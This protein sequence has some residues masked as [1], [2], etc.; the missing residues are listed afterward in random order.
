MDLEPESLSAADRYGLLIALIAPRPIAWVSTVDA[1]GRPNLAPFSFFTGV[2][3]NPMTVCFCPANHRSGGKKDTLANVEATGE[4]VVNVVGESLAERMNQTSA[5]Y[6][7]GVSEF[8]EAGLTPAPSARV[9]PPYVK[10]S[11]AQLECRLHQIVRVGEGPLAGNLVIGTVV[12]ARVADPVWKDGRVSHQD[13]RPIGR[14]E[15]AWYTRVSDAFEMKRP[16]LK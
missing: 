7:R 10:E 14:L 3:G 16:R 12:F 1:E 13:L 6:P 4:F 11:P 8:G 5:E 15:G 9:R 2:T